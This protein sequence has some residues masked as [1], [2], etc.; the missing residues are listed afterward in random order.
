M[1]ITTTTLYSGSVYSAKLKHFF[2]NMQLCLLLILT[3]DGLCS[4]FSYPH[5]LW[6]SF[7]SDGDLW[8]I[9]G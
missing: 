2:P 6:W 3:I 8:V 7:R 9:F 5:E 1:I 4:D